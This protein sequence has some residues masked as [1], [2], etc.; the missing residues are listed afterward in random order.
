ML[1][2]IKQGFTLIENDEVKDTFVYP[3]ISMKFQPQ[4]SLLS[5]REN[6]EQMIYRVTFDEYKMKLEP[7]YE[8]VYYTNI[9][10]EELFEEYYNLGYEIVYY[11]EK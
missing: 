9:I 6:N 7:I 8:E 11:G 1:Y 4:K 5:V 2:R 10:F 3:M